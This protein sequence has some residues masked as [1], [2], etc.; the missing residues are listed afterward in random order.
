MVVGALLLVVGVVSFISGDGDQDVVAVG[1]TTTVPPT[2]GPTVTVAQ[3]TTPSATTT[4]TTTPTT[5]TEPPETPEEFLA[6]LVQGLR[7]DPEL[8]VSR[9]N[10]ATIDI[11]GAEQCLATLTDVLD[12]ET[13]FEIRE[14]GPV[15]PWDYVIDDI[16]TPL[17]D[18]LAIE[19]E[20]FVAG[21]TI[22]Q[23]L[24]WQLVDGLWTW[25]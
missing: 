9:L 1:S 18:I 6:L 22:I 14:I 20:R 4:T 16:V 21:Q 15:G 23:E 13:T 10:Q 2:T 11:Y 5:T 12:P 3:S 19:V 24:H 25:F 8:L 7:E 17:E